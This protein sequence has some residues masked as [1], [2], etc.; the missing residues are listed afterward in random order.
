MFKRLFKKT[1]HKSSPPKLSIVDQMFKDAGFTYWEYIDNIYRNSSNGGLVNISVDKY[2]ADET[3]VV[4]K[5]IDYVRADYIKNDFI[6]DLNNEVKFT[7]KMSDLELGPK[8]YFSYLNGSAFNGKLYIITEAMDKDCQQYFNT[9]DIRNPIDKEDIKNVLTQ[10]VTLIKKQ[11]ENK[12]YCNDQKPHNFI[13]NEDT[14]KVRLIDFGL[15]YDENPFKRIANEE[16]NDLLYFQQLLQLR[17]FLNFDKEV[18]N[19][20]YTDD[21]FK[22]SCYYLNKYY[23]YII[24]SPFIYYYK[25]LYDKNNKKT[26]EQIYNDIYNLAECSRISNAFSK[27]QQ[28][29]RRR[30][31][32]SKR[33]KRRSKRRFLSPQ[34]SLN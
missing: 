34:K 12:I 7:K 9:K 27:S 6:S 11:I 15:C 21:I 17:L 5:I 32:K 1:P 8:F 23:D 24:D 28:R 31:Q 30:S 2:K 4:V 16:A 19:P 26:D 10:M 14:Q 18:L 13:I 3:F 20:I 33:S 25:I 22:N 29:R